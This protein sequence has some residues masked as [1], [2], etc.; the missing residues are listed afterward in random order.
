MQ[1]SKNLIVAVLSL[2]ALA[3]FVFAPNTARGDH[4]EEAS[5]SYRDRDWKNAVEKFGHFITENEDD[6]RAITAAFFM[7]EALIELE[8]YLDAHEAYALYLNVAPEDSKFLRRARFRL[9]ESAYMGKNWAAAMEAF[10]V[11]HREYPEDEL[12]AYSLPYLAEITS[13]FGEHEVA[14]GV[15][16]A[17]IARFQDGPMITKCQFGL[18]RSLELTKKFDDARQVYAE[19]AES[20]EHRDRATFYLAL[21]EYNR[22][23]LEEAEA[24]L[25]EVLSDR[26]SA[27]RLESLYWRGMG[28]F[29][30]GDHEAAASDFEL[31]LRVVPEKHAM[32]ANLHRYLAESALAQGE[33]SE[34]VRILTQFLADR[35]DQPLGDCRSTLLVALARTGDWT[36]VETKHRHHRGSP[37]GSFHQQNCLAQGPAAI[38]GDRGKFR[39][40]GTATEVVEAGRGKRRSIGQT[41]PGEA[42]R[43]GSPFPRCIQA[44]S[45]E[46]S[47]RNARFAAGISGATAAI[48]PEGKG[49]G[50]LGPLSP[51]PEGSEAVR[52]GTF[53]DRIPGVRR[54]TRRPIGSVLAPVGGGLQAVWCQGFGTTLFAGNY[55]PVS[56][57]YVPGR[58]LFAIGT[59]R[60]AGWQS[61][62]RSRLLRPGSCQ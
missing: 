50:C 59:I 10:D 16:Q 23:D 49:V 15:F 36:Q 44:E 4:F 14:I 39:R 47:I 17:A 38:G 43:T 24:R 57:K 45:N 58:M 13:R 28:R 3:L 51:T 25:T 27:Y 53:L 42:C 62:D 32:V 8:L 48:A 33:A 21:L 35:D 31:A 55:G 22:N 5:Q 56:R 54:A 1:G 60:A 30:R 2:T 34:A 41:R 7:A 37:A 46:R 29:A 11:F 20:E 9:G 19:L 26:D 18:A 6:S 61:P 12:Q 52:C 40:N